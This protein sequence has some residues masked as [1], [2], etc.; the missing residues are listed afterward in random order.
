MPFSILLLTSA[1]SKTHI[2]GEKGDKLSMER[3]ELQDGELVLFFDKVDAGPARLAL[4]MNN[5]KCC[6]GI[7][8]YKNNT[9]NV[10]CLVEMK[11]TDPGD[12]KEQ[13]K[14]TYD[15]LKHL[16]DKECESCKDYLRQITWK[17]YIRCWGSSP[18]SKYRD[19]DSL[20]KYGFK[21]ERMC[22]DDDIINYLRGEMKAR[23]N[24]KPRG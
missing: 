21:D 7:I 20:K 13:I 22:R 5:Q 15:R 17:A 11:H 14:A 10:I 19:G 18:T 16:L 9:Q 2:T 3:G 8:F 12:A 24:K 4:G 6:D 1:S 23:K